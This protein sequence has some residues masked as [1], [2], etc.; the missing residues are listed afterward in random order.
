MRRGRGAIRAGISA[1]LALMSAGLLLV[2]LSGCQQERA[3]EPARGAFEGVSLSV[4]AVGDPEILQS[5]GTQTGEW[6][7]EH[8]AQVNVLPEPGAPDAAR[9]ADVLI[10]PGDRLGDLVD[11]GAI[12]PLPESA[13][14]PETSL[15]AP[16][17][18]ALPV[19]G[20]E[21]EGDDLD[22]RPGRDPLDFSDVVLP[23]R[24]QVTKYGDDRIGLPLGGSALVLVYR[25]D[26]LASEALR[27]EAAS[28]GVS[29]GPP[30]TWEQLDALARFLHGR[31][32]DPARD[33]P[34][35]GIAL[36]LGDDPEGVADAIFLARAA[37]LGQ[38]PDRYEFLFDSDTMEPRVASP[39]FVEAL[40]AL[41]ALKEAG[42]EGMAGFDAEKARAAFREGKAALLIDR[43]ERA[44]KWTEKTAPYP[45]G[46]ARL[47]GSPRVFDPSRGAWLEAP[48]PNRPGFLPRGGGWLAGVSAGA[49]GPRREAAIALVRSLAGPELSQAIASDPIFPMASVRGSH[50]T[51]GLIYPGLTSNINGKAWGDAV[52]STYAGDRAVVG[53]RIPDAAG[54]L[55]DLSRARASASRGEP[56]ES[57]LKAAAAAWSARTDRLGKDRQLWHYRRS[58]NKLSTPSEPPPRGKPEAGRVDK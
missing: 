18:A 25:Q 47:P 50:L 12:A 26:A 3:D 56:A 9:S 41:S 20:S 7:R 28:A 33:E 32:W 13:V 8:G 36:A 40:S 53:L 4:A 17:K 22:R 21:E 45:V 29:L 27:E 38:P 24:E 42:P 23:Y 52:S 14:R 30:E 58:L 49:T 5:V 34:G 48:T 19:A 46:V 37:C 35:S 57:A 10:F 2:G 54:Y 43:A 11:V 51:L 15:P 44:A 6:A 16:G 31:K 55:A 1:A 39:P